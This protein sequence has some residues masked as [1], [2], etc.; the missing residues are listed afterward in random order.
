MSTATATAPT[1]MPSIDGIAYHVDPLADDR[2]AWRARRADGKGSYTVRL[3]TGG[4]WSCNCPAF[5]FGYSRL[6]ARCKHAAMLRGMATM[7]GLRTEPRW[8]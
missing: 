2:Q 4:K 6:G 3:E 5:H 1:W 8:P 7:L